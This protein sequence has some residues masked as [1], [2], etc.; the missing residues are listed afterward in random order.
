MNIDEN[1]PDELRDKVA[2]SLMKHKRAALIG[3]KDRIN[4]KDRND[5]TGNP[6]S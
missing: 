1:D 4:Q 2:K 6:F 5:P 3:N